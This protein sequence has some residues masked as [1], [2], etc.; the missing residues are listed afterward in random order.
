MEVSRAGFCNAPSK[1]LLASLQPMRTWRSDEE[2]Q[3][4]QC[5]KASCSAATLLSKPCRW[6]VPCSRAGSSPGAGSQHHGRGRG[7]SSK[8]VGSWL[9]R[10]K[11]W[12]GR[13][14]SCGRSVEPVVE[15]Y[16][17]CPACPGWMRVLWEG[18]QGALKAGCSSLV[19]H[20]KLFW[21]LFLKDK[22]IT[23]IRRQS[24]IIWLPWV[25]PFLVLKRLEAAASRVDVNPEPHPWSWTWCYSP[26]SEGGCRSCCPP[27]A[28][29]G[30]V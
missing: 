8:Q 26:R 17:A 23:P 19:K 5:S 27:A 15:V 10:F 14:W 12:T 30:G 18:R 1:N 22:P 6:A 4:P 9:P 2:Q 21:S 28:H 13:G 7:R 3:S 11:C 24:C 25:P 20:N 16:L 29:A